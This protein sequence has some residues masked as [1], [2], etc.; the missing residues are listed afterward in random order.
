M[1]VKLECTQTNLQGTG[2]ANAASVASV[3]SAPDVAAPPRKRDT[4]P[5]KKAKKKAAG[6]GWMKK[7]L[8]GL[9]VGLLL[10]GAGQYATTTAADDVPSTQVINERMS[11]LAKA[12][13]ADPTW[14]VN[15]NYKD[16]PYY[17]EMGD[18]NPLADFLTAVYENEV[19]Q[20]EEEMK[21]F[22]S[23]RDGYTFQEPPHP[24][25]ARVYAKVN[26]RVTGA[27][28]FRAMGGREKVHTDF[29]G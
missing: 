6:M 1:P 5:R 22:V 18:E 7:A 20:Y 13:R 16:I 10:F 29:V 12:V 9:G 24:T 17:A 23:K 4:A 14:T 15:S 21:N 3:A 28:G 19:A 27:R 26:A 2:L 11:E 25:A 8:L